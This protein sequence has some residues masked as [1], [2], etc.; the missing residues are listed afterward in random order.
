MILPSQLQLSSDDIFYLNRVAN[1][2]LEKVSLWFQSNKLTLNVSKT[3]YAIFKSKNMNIPDDGLSLR[4]GNET[5]ERIG[6][7]MPEKNF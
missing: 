5:I 6:D 3:K 1:E 7:D 2:E 4:I